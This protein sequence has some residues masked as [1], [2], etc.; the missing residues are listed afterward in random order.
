MGETRPDATHRLTRGW[1]VDGLM[2]MFEEAGL[3]GSGL[4]DDL[5]RYLAKIEVHLAF[6]PRASRDTPSR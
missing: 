1:S 6:T 5:T 4:T 3:H 2:E